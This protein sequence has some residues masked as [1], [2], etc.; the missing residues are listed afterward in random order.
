MSLRSLRSLSL[1]WSLLV[2]AAAAAQV[3]PRELVAPVE[4]R[5]AR[6]EFARK[7]HGAT[8]PSGKGWKAVADR[9]KRLQLMVPDRWKVEPDPEGEAALR[10]AP[11]GSDGARTAV[12]QVFLT[13]PRD[14]DPL[15]VEEAFA[16]AYADELAEE[17]ALRMLRFTPT[18]SGFVLVRDLKFA[19]AGGTLVRGKETYR[20][21]QL[22]FIGEDRV[23]SIQFTCLEREFPRYADDLARIFASYRNLAVRRIT[24]P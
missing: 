3:V 4:V 7:L 18:D 13:P 8:M 10:I 22:L 9:A 5:H 24:A 12:L 16:A 1:G 14:D 23:V 20:Q 21:Q 15:E 17:P 6:G 19:L 2:A 11:P